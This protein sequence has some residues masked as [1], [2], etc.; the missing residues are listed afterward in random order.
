MSDLKIIKI[1][2]SSSIEDIESDILEVKAFFGT[3]NDIYIDWNI[4]FSIETAAPDSDES[5]LESI[6]NSELTFL[7][8][9]CLIA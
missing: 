8:T 3:L 4:F 6:G 2:I 9:R 7:K 1:I 5:L